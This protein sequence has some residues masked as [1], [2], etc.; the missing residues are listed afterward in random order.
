MNYA[1]D[2]C[3]FLDDSPVNFYAVDTVRRRLEAEGFSEL[4]MEDCWALKPGDRRFVVKNGTA[5]FAF[6][7]G[8]GFPE[9][10]FNIVSANSDS[11][12]F[13]SVLDSA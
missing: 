1:A 3:A 8:T 6:I 11:P 5:I 4:K 10:V 2:L 9:R 13:E 12:C 7:V